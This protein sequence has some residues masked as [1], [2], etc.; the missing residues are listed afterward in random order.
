M[1]GT[2]KLRCVVYGMM[3]V[4]ALLTTTAQLQ[5][6]LPLGL[7]EGNI[8]FWRD[9]MA[10]AGSRFITM[11]VLFVFAAVWPW[12]VSE[13][14]RLKMSHYGWY[15]PAAAVISFSATLPVFMI[16]REVMLARSGQGHDTPKTGF[17]DR[18]SMVLALAAALAY[19]THA[20]RNLT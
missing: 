10:N 19:A 1:R 2:Q 13:G 4:V 7:L 20:S 6:Y 14:R 18:L 8:Q 12:M 15:L 11:D 9:T 17:W 16:H 3:S 5:A